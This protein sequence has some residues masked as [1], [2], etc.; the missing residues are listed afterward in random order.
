M[1]NAQSIYTG[2]G[3]T[4]SY[5]NSF[6]QQNSNILLRTFS[7]SSGG[8]P[9]VIIQEITRTATV[10][11]GSGP[12]TRQMAG[13]AGHYF[14]A[15][16]VDAQGNVTP[17]GSA[18]VTVLGNT[19]P[20][21]TDPQVQNPVPYNDMFGTPIQYSDITYGING[22]SIFIPGVSISQ[23]LQ[24][25]EFMPGGQGSNWGD[26]PHAFVSPTFQAAIAALPAINVNSVIAHP[27]LTLGA[28]D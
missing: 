17:L 27:H 22:T 9:G 14:E 13:D 28:T 11:L 25:G 26:L 16:A 18:G 20:Y 1:A 2:T 23:L 5:S 8:V 7:V 15:W 4:F 19:A 24:S 21:I 10:D 3:F 12:V 6:G